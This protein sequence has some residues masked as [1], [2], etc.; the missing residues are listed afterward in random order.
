VKEVYETLMNDSLPEELN[1]IEMKL[2]F[3]AIPSS[4]GL[5]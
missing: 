1:G 3:I 2:V 5:N 4:V